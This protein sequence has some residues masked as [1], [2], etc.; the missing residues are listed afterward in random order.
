MLPRMSA[1]GGDGGRE[2]I[3]ESVVCLT[4]AAKTKS[5]TCARICCE[6]G[7]FRFEVRVDVTYCSVLVLLLVRLLLLR[8]PR[9]FQKPRT[10]TRVAWWVCMLATFLSGTFLS[11]DREATG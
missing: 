9:T 11:S 10:T 2:V 3:G 7:G 1:S 5:K 4:L 6:S 8:R